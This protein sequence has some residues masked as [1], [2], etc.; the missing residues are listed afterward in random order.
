LI[1]RR[2]GATS[3]SLAVA[4]VRDGTFNG[5]RLLSWLSEVLNPG[6]G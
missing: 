4:S 3:P 1:F 5:E 2:S 6:K